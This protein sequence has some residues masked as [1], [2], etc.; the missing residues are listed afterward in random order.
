M[1]VEGH[2][3]CISAYLSTRSILASAAHG[4]HRRVT[5]EEIARMSGEGDAVCANVTRQAGWALGVTV[6]MVVNLTTVKTVI[7]GG[8]S[9]DVARAGHQDIERGMSHRRFHDHRSIET[10]MLSSG[11]SQWARGGAVEAIRTFVVEGR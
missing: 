6:A 11:F 2:R 5:L 1:C 7:V 8:E 4:L 10:P 9:V 3:G